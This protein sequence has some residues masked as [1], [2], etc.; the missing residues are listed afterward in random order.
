MHSAL[1][2]LSTLAFA[3]PLAAAADPVEPGSYQIDNQHSAAFFT[4]THMGVSRF[5]G[6]FNEVNGTFVVDATGKNSKTSVTIPATSID[7][8]HE[9]RDT[10]LKGPDFFN[11]VEFPNL[12]FESSQTKL[13]AGGNGTLAGNLTMHGVSKPVTFTLK[14]IGGGKGMKGE[15]R[16]G[17]VA[18]ATIKRSD[19]GISYGLPKAVSDDVDLTINIEGIKQ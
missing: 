3:L 17:Y 15:T 12:S 5:T 8:A 6:R 18:T 11:V 4:V 16:A 19:F 7:T 13:D 2:L 10:H 9:K 14:Q 1:R